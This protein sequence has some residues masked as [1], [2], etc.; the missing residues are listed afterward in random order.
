MTTTIPR[1]TSRLFLCRLYGSSDRCFKT[2]KRLSRLDGSL[3]WTRECLGLAWSMTKL[4][5]GAPSGDCLHVGMSLGMNTAASVP[6][7]CGKGPG[8]PHMP[9]S[10]TPATVRSR[11]RFQPVGVRL[12]SAPQHLTSGYGRN[13]IAK[14]DQWVRVWLNVVAGIRAQ[15]TTLG[16]GPGGALLPLAG[17]WQVRRQ[18]PY[19][20][21]VTGS[22][23]PTTTSTIVTV[24]F[25][26][27]RALWLL[28]GSTSTSAAVAGSV[29][30]PPSSRSP[31]K[32]R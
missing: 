7:T 31:S 28:R 3:S 5:A 29:A 8:E 13:K 15:A 27:L 16:F 10:L 19:R 11:F 4:I 17:D 6:L 18:G 23:A 30:V 26:W 12:P 20:L 14:L 1:H 25:Q 32:S 21:S 9:R 24:C 2:A 22:M